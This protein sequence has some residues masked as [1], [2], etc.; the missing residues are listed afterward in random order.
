VAE[1][2]DFKADAISSEFFFALGA[3]VCSIGCSMF[4]YVSLFLINMT[5]EAHL[6]RFPDQESSLCAR[7]CAR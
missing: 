7:V 3:N 4:Q 5:V 2:A 6:V 1:L